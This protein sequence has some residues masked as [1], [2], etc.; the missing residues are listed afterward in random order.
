MRASEASGRSIL[1]MKMC[2]KKQMH[3]QNFVSTSKQVYPKKGKVIYES[4]L[5]KLLHNECN[6]LT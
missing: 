4:I 5:R 6:E 1:L 3:M 2:N